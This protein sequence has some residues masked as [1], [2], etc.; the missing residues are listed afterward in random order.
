[1]MPR[2]NRSSRLSMSTRG[3]AHHALLLGELAFEVER[4]LPVE[5]GILGLWRRVMPARL[6][7]LRHRMLPD[8]GLGL[9]SHVILQRS[10]VHLGSCPGQAS[11]ENTVA[12]FHAHVHPMDSR[13][14]PPR[15]A[16]SRIAAPGAFG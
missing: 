3:V 4:V 14:L 16:R 15:P 12:A 6:G 8:F 5:R 1:M 2:S 11:P 13:G 10:G 7:G 9:G